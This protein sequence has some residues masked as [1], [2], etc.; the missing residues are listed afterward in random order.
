MAGPDTFT[1][2]GRDGIHLVADAYGPPAAPPV[3]FL[4][5][6]GQ[7][8]HSWGGTARAVADRGWRA[9]TVDARGHGESDWSPI[10]DYRVVSFATDVGELAGRLA[11][12]P[13]LVGAS[14]GGLTSMLYAGELARDAVRGVVLVDIV[15]DM[16]QVGAERIRAFMVD[17]TADG[18]ASLEEVADAVAAYNPH[19]D[20]PVDVNG[21][22]K[23]LREREG[24]WYWHWDPVFMSGEGEYAPVEIL[25]V[26]RLHAAIGNVVA[27]GVPLLL[28]RGR[29]SD[30]VSEVRAQEFLDRF[31]QCEFV[32]V[33]GAGHMVAGDRN[34]AFTTAVVDF[35][36][37]HHG[38]S[39]PG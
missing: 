24:R 2:D 1:F 9:V 31:P 28:V 17:R 34:D 27:D 26:D 29:M 6:G 8:R 33:S 10:G 38:A 23:N 36:E 13:I 16:D 11:T 15:P 25:D 14:L 30:L 35:L 20:R 39:P 21:L 37:R 22:R 3:V 32:D 19:R 5:G 4:H 18:F 7:T 12:P